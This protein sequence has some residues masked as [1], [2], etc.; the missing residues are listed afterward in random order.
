MSRDLY[1]I[2]LTGNIATGK[3]AVAGMLGDL[4]AHVI[5]ADAL[6]HEVTRA[7]TPAWQVVVDAFG[8]DVLQA[9]GEI[10]RARL[11]ARVFS[12][13]TALAQLETIVHPA[14]IAD[15]ER[16]LE[17]LRHSASPPAP[18]IPVVVLEA[19]KLLESGLAQRCA[20]V[21][22]VTSAHDQQVQRLTERRGL[23]VEAA[24]L[25]IA[26]QPP[27]SEKVARADVVI[28]NSGNLEQTRVQVSREWQRIMNAL[29]PGRLAA[30]GLAQGGSMSSL[31]Q[32][33]EKHIFLS[34]WAVLAVGMVVIFLLS[35]RSVALLASQRLF[36][37]L[38]C[39]GLAG[40][41]TWIIS[42][43]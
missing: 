34:M 40:V 32:W 11:G 33:V 18:A 36:M 43:E 20:E 25:R 37:A 24:D 7:G 27:Q 28:D 14:V 8:R 22:V 13:A 38:A 35:S 6:A 1:L 16:Q 30:P 9:N 10:D 12:D 2:G 39:V 19:I 21:W 3:S 41:C 4:G 5:D 31:R 23:S 17:E 42:W 29:R 15:T 26:A